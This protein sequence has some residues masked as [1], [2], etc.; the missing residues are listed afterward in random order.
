MNFGYLPSYYNPMDREYD[1]R[2]SKET[3][4]KEV[5]LGNI[6]ISTSPMSNQLDQLKARI[7]QGASAVELGFSGRGKGSMGGQNTTPEMY[8]AD[9]REDIRQM[10]DF[11]KVKLSTH[12]S[13]N[14]GPMSGMTQQGF[15][16]S[17]REGTLREIE[18]AIDFAADT[19]RGGAVV[20][21]T[22]EFP[23]ALS[24]MNREKYGDFEMFPAESNEATMHLVDRQT[25]Q[26]IQSVKKN[27]PVVMP[28]FENEK[29]SKDGQIDLSRVEPL[30]KQGWWP[31]PHYDEEGTGEFQVRE[32]S[33]DELEKIREWYN[34]KARKAA[35]DAGKEPPKKMSTEEVAY[36]ATIE[37][38]RQYALGWAKDYADRFRSAKHTFDVL[39][40]AKSK[41]N[42]LDKDYSLSPTQET[43]L[44]NNRVLPQ[45]FSRISKEEKQKYLAEGGDERK[46]QVGEAVSEI[47]DN[48][49]RTMNSSREASVSQFQQAE[50]YKR[51]EERAVPIQ[52]YATEKTADTIARAAEF[53]HRKSDMLKE[54]GQ[55][56][57]P[58][59]VSPENI[60]PETYGAHPQEL[61]QIIHDAREKYVEEYKGTYGESD[62]RKYAEEHIK[63]T[64]DI[65]HAYTWRKY[66][67]EDSSKSFEEN[68]KDFKKWLMNQVDDLN[69]KGYIQHIHVSDNFGWEDEHV[70][71]GQGRVPIKEFIDKMKGAGI[72][73]VTVEPAHQDFRAM[74]GA[75]REFGAPIYG[76]DQ[77]LQ[78]WTD[79][80]FSYFG[81]T[82]S[83]YFVFGEYAPSQDF[84]LW[85][86]V[87][88]E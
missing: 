2:P 60:F 51:M 79:V 10:A 58:I 70:T 63:G 9:E 26:I 32:R 33:W 65:G 49:T 18:R 75:W 48:A 29:I 42:N 57:S 19:A 13:Y 16:N 84:T 8:G 7:F 30:E 20:V 59:Y 3:P 38:R 12:A 47:L 56:K 55:L 53:A 44:I 37:S 11:N 39:G 40:D 27:Q 66:Y 52:Q 15:D 45:D 1:N 77:S 41:V 73:E 69:K 61:K 74:L 85:S 64:F 82:R 25:G 78:K 22:G 24:E 46:K 76:A 31:N 34:T 4:L 83:P 86:Q 21:H 67:K 36:R 87:P 17:A 80:Q 72:S 43:V 88:L 68:E 5:E 81:K 14:I 28:V 71:P 50:E 6:G 62:A 54:R 35:I 23:R